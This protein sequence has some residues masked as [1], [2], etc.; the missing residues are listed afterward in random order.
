MKFHIVAVGNKLPA[1][2][3]NAFTEYSKRFPQE[4]TLQLTE[5]KPEKRT[6]NKNK[7]Q[8][9]GAEFQRIKTSIPAGCR[10]IALD[11][12][13]VQYTTIQLADV[14]EKWMQEG[15]DTVF[16]I[17][18]AD[19]LHASIK[20]SAHATLSLSKLTFP[21]GL[22]RVILA[23]QLYRAISLIKHHPYHRI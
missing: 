7:E 2:V 20:S 19:G 22:A 5:I 6:N 3:N 12:H 17:G 1:W 23:E 11:V 13:G 9:L 15:H 18:G 14:I 10:I 21:H 4:I 16:V 8:L